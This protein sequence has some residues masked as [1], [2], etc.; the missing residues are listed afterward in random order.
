M[1]QFIEVIKLVSSDDEDNPAPPPHP[2]VHVARLMPLPASAVVDLT[3][4]DQ[5]ESNIRSSSTTSGI[6]TGRKQAPSAAP[7]AAELVKTKKK[8]KMTPTTNRFSFHPDDTFSFHQRSKLRFTIRGE[9]CVLQRTRHIGNRVYSPSG[10]KKQDF[11][12]ACKALFAA[13]SINGQHLFNEFAFVDNQHLMIVVIIRE[14]R[15]QSDF[16]MSDASHCCKSLMRKESAPCLL[17]K[18]HGDID[19]YAKF[20]L[21]ALTGLLYQDDKQVVLLSAARVLDNRD[22]CTGAINIMVK[23]VTERQVCFC[24]KKTKK[25]SQGDAELQQCH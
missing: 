19:N 14:K 20:V 8:P 16:C 24:W 9:P 12:N 10:A 21:D 18:G 22:A 17:G 2:M 1:D 4:D 23:N 5:D 11:Q 7:L 6:L 13:K 15:P 3:A 25:S